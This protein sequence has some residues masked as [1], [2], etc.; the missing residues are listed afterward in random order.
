M[1]T[2]KVYSTQFKSTAEINTFFSKLKATGFV[3]WYNKY[4]AG[5][6]EFK[7]RNTIKDEKGFTKVWSNIKNIYD[8]DSVNL[9]EF[10]CLSTSIIIETGATFKPITEGVNS[11]S[12]ASNPGISYAYNT[13]QGLKASYNNNTSLG[14]KSAYELFNNNDYILAHGHKPYGSLLK[15]TTDLRW[16]SSQFPIGF[17][18]NPTKEVSTNIADNSFIAESDFNKFRG[19]GLIQTTG[20]NAYKKLIRYILEYT[21]QNS[22]IISFKSKWTNYGQDYDKIANI[23]T[24]FD[25]NEIFQETDYIIPSSAI[26]LFNKSKNNFLI[27]DPNQEEVPLKKSIRNVGLFI[28]GGSAYANR[29]L[30]EVSQF[31]DSINS[32]LP[33]N[34]TT[35]N[36]EFTN[37]ISPTQS[38]IPQNNPPAPPIN[39]QE[40]REKDTNKDLNTNPKSGNAPRI[41]GLENFF[42]PSIDVKFIDFKLASNNK[43]RTDEISDTLGYLPFVWYNSVQLEPNFISSFQLSCDSILPTIKLVFSDQYG[44]FSFENQGFP[45]D[46][47]KIKVFIASRSKTLK[48]I[49]MDFKITVFKKISNSL[50][51]IE[52]ICDINYFFLK[53][54]ESYS[55]KTSFDALQ[56]FAKKSSL[57]FNSN[58]KGTND[59]MSWI[60]VGGR[61]IDFLMK[62]ISKAYKSDDAFLWCYVDLFYNLNF[63]DVETAFNIKIEGVGN[64]QNM[65]LG[66]LS[67]LGV[68]NNEQVTNLIL[69]NDKSFASTN[70]YFSDYKIIN[71]STQISIKNGYLNRAK[72]YDILNSEYSVFDVDSITSPGDK[73]I[74]M[75][76]QPTDDVF[77]NE[78]ITET[79]VGKLDADNMH[80]NY[81]YS[82]IQNKQNI[83]DIQKIGIEIKLTKPNFNIYRFQKAYVLFN[84]DTPSLTST[85]VN[86]RLSGEWLVLNL[87]FVKN[88]DNFEQYISLIRRE[89]SLSKQEAQS[90]PRSN[91]AKNNADNVSPS[92]DDKTQDNGIANSSNPDNANTQPNSN[93]DVNDSQNQQNNLDLSIT[94]KNSSELDSYFVSY[95]YKSF[96]DWFNKTQAFKGAFSANKG[97]TKSHNWTKTWNNIQLLYGKQD[98]NLIEFICLNTIFI[99]TTIGKFES[100]TEIVNSTTA[101]SN[102]GISYAFNINNTKLSY[103]TLSSNKTAYD[104]FRDADYKAAHSNKPFSNILVDTTDLR[105]QSEQFP[106]G[107]S[108]GDTKK[109]ISNNPADNGFIYEAD[110]LKFRSRGYV[111][112]L[113]RGLYKALLQYIISYTGNNITLL[114]YKNDWIQFN[115]NLDKVLSISTNKDWDI[116][117]NETDS[118]IAS[119]SVFIQSNTKQLYQIINPKQP[120][121]SLK[122]SIR[123][124][125]KNSSSYID[126]NLFEGKINQQID[127]LQKN[128]KTKND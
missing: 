69:S 18:N 76:G 15:D 46:D 97:I 47:S 86:N 7:G 5:K 12:N 67:R 31:L 66:A 103:N 68:E 6:G 105:W 24:N 2:Q 26:N 22:K 11:I 14:N 33:A 127:W 13:I 54:F 64:V 8:K 49:L 51:S 71:K 100:V 89:L 118:I 77:F 81:N 93:G 124:V 108:G 92:T 1:P 91:P 102:P 45:L 74:I 30:G 117:F 125:A 120:D 94:F 119:K 17:S 90:E 80:K 25:W 56:D 128:N 29:F 83:E 34:E 111:Q 58:I 121:E 113:S 109:E 96:V 116:L 123:N 16:Q 72:F 106:I 110:F 99:E 112:F 19:R 36:N 32:N 63:I 122:K 52:G 28:N 43:L 44:N 101:V 62:T 9:I 59:Q 42:K 104:L 95:G 73:T 53:K 39:E 98:C 48:P 55:K 41:D 21:G 70:M 65:G 114:K 37:P 88:G 78:H 10:L 82:E 57:G 75:K 50:Y 107:F 61:G 84:T 126:I 115:N 3:D 40:S 87:R 60:N 20:R 27:I 85:D 35:S 38:S 23:S 4:H 79:Y